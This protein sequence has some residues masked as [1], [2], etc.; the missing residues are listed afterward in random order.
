M[1][2]HVKTKWIIGLTGSILSGKSTALAYFKAC[3]A[4]V[5]SCDVIAGELYTRPSVLKKIKTG[6][7]TTDKAQ[8]ARLVFKEADKRKVLEQILHPLILKEVKTQI[9]ACAQQLV[10]IEAPLL[11]EAGWEKYTD[12]NICVL[13]DPQTL[14]A[15]LKGRNLSPAEYRRRLKH[16]LPPREK[17][18]RADIVFFH[19]NKGQLQR[20]V[21]RFC[22]AFNLLHKQK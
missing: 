12:L 11:F 14:P 17:A 18:S 19:T 9:K 13:A 10:V 1:S 20:S 22:Q 16:Q 2:F 3:G 6:L 21:A 4:G 8:L 15:R 7:G 5:I